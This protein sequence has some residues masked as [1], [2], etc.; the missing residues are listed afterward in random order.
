[1]RFE[2]FAG[3]VHLGQS[4]SISESDYVV[5]LSLSSL[6][7]DNGSFKGL[8]TKFVDCAFKDLRF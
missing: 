7:N 2:V 1:M 6:F 4:L 5:A 3:T 8:Q